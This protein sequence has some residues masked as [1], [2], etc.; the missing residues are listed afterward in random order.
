M[1]YHDLKEKLKILYS[2]KYAA[3]MKEESDMIEA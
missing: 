2:K 1:E 3:M